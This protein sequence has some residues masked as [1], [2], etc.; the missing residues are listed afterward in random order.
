[1]SLG[2]SDYFPPPT[3]TDLLQLR[4][5]RPIFQ[6]NIF[7]PSM[8]YVVVRNC[9]DLSISNAY[10]IFSAIHF[11]LS[12]NGNKSF[13]GDITFPVYHAAKP[14]GLSK[15]HIRYVLSEFSSSF[16]S[17]P[18]PILVRTLEIFYEENAWNCIG[19][20][21]RHAYRKGSM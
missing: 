7:T 3:A 18:Q 8:F 11:N 12:I 17:V 10:L 15:K 2:S 21:C 1:M 14:L 6:P 5:T 13:F 9:L 4:L 16:D 19:F 20:S